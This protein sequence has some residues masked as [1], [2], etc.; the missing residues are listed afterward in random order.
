[1]GD[2]SDQIFGQVAKGFAVG[3]VQREETHSGPSQTHY[4]MTSKT[5]GLQW[6]VEGNLTDQAVTVMNVGRELLARTQ[7]AKTNFNP[8][9]RYC[10]LHVQEKV[11]VGLVICLLLAVGLI[12]A[13]Q[14]EVLDVD[15]Y[16]AA[17]RVG[18]PPVAKTAQEAPQGRVVHVNDIDQPPAAV[19]PDVRR[20]VPVSE[21]SNG[22]RSP[23]RACGGVG[24]GLCKIANKPFP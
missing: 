6:L 16:F 24:C 15:D 21:S 23:C 18:L 19:S 20:N 10:S 9:C 7:K 11:D 2:A 13:Q 3:Q 17:A 8:D 1:M 12:E 5:A 22:S 4:L 14:P